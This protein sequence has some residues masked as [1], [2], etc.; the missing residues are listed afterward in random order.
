L[1]C[2]AWLPGQKGTVSAP[3]LWT[4]P[5][6]GPLLQAAACTDAI[7][8]PLRG[9]RRT[10]SRT[11]RS[12]Q[13]LDNRTVHRYAKRPDTGAPDQLSQL[14]FRPSIHLMPPFYACLSQV[15]LAWAGRWPARKENALGQR[16]GLL[17]N[18]RDDGA[19][20]GI[21]C[22]FGCDDFPN[23]RVALY[24]QNLQGQRRGR[25]ECRGFSGRSP[26]NQTRYWWS[27]LQRRSRRRHLPLV[28][29]P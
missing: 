11:P 6:A 8:H 2:T 21:K 1:T 15:Y 25:R 3:E 13:S 28:Q 26:G 23:A 4:G 7:P 18:E 5:I 14:L 19:P 22:I 27:G 12:E 17:M 9:H 16:C 20:L 24:D 29:P 10:T